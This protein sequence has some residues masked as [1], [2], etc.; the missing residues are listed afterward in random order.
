MHLSQ[1]P[2]V[3]PKIA[4]RLTVAARSLRANLN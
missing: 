4:R 1:V 3:E 2:H